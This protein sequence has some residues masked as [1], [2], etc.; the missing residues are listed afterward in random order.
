M[1]IPETQALTKAEIKLLLN[2][3]K[4]NEVVSLTKDEAI[5]DTELFFNA[6]KYAYGAYYYYGED[7]FEASKTKALEEIA[8][9]EEITNRDLLQILYYS[10]DFLEDGHLYMAGPEDMLFS[11]GENE[12]KMLR[13]FYNTDYIFTQDSTGFYTEIEGEKWYYIESDKDDVWRVSIELTLLEDGSLVYCPTM[14]TKIIDQ[15]EQCILTL[16]KGTE[17]MELPVSWAMATAAGLEEN[18]TDLTVEGVTYFRIGTFSNIG[19]ESK[20]LKKAEEAGKQNLLIF[21]LR[22]NGGGIDSYGLHF[23]ESFV[24]KEGTYD[25]E[26]NITNNNALTGDTPYGQENWTTWSRTGSFTEN[27]VP[28]I[29]LVDDQCMSACEATIRYFKTLDNVIV[30]GSNTAGGQ[31]TRANTDLHLPASGIY[32]RM[33]STAN[34]LKEIGDVEAE[35]YMPDIWCNPYTSLDAVLKLAEKQI[36]DTKPLSLE[37]KKAKGD[38][39][40]TISSPLAVVY[41]NLKA[42][43][44]FG[45]VTTEEGTP[46]DVYADGK[47]ITNFE[48]DFPDA[49]DITWAEKTDNGQFMIYVDRKPQEEE[50]LYR[51]YITYEGETYMWR[52]Y[53]QF[54]DVDENGNWTS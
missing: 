22:G 31:L 43:T 11:F 40:L 34:F 10:L 49:D 17:R 41:T 38:T 37:M 23:I 5:S 45:R 51:I 33:G 26:L 28:V 6:F 47:K 8:A 16:G 3:K 13:Y 35:G 2:S 4:V 20:L 14:L 50:R 15:E 54:P 21:D 1:A 18:I 19:D 44:G 12:T 52:L 25:T 9:A 36:M 46:F 27:D 53:Q 7:K 24:G 29:I 48:L 32:F 30:V 39:V 42:G